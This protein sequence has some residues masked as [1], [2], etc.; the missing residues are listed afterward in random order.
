MIFKSE[1]VVSQLIHSLTEL[2]IRQD[3][4]LKIWFDAIN[5]TFVCVNLKCARLI[6]KKGRALLVREKSD[7]VKW[8]RLIM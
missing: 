8:A 5:W 4:P 3:D 6:T 7:P 1:S 2:K